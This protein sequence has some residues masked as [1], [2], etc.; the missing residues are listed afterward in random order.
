M[1][2]LEK[3][4]GLICEFGVATGRSLRMIQEILPL[5][6]SLYGFDT[7]T[8]LPTP[9]GEE[10]AGAYSTDGAVPNI[11]GKVRLISPKL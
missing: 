2:L 10:P 8:G 3:E 4:N 5:G 6:T 7:F 11:E 9:W 1:P